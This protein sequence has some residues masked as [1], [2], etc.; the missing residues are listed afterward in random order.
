MLMRLAG[1][2]SAQSP[3]WTHQLPREGTPAGGLQGV[4]W[5]RTG[6]RVMWPER[7]HRQK[8][9]PV[10]VRMSAWEWPPSPAR[11]RRGQHISP[12]F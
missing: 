6:P 9:R 11:Q 12:L 1:T 3:R 8:E 10:S 5:V 2:G 7:P 4:R